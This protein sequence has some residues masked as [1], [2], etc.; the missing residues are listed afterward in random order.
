VYV[1]EVKSPG[2]T[3]RDKVM[4]GGAKA[5]LGMEKLLAR[6]GRPFA[7]DGMI[8]VAKRPASS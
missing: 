6:L 3:T 5:I 1:Q 7:A 8:V 4:A 2:T